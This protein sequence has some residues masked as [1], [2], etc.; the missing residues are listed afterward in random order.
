MWQVRRK[1]LLADRLTAETCCWLPAE[2]CPD[3]QQLVDA[4]RAG[5]ALQNGLTP[6]VGHLLG[7]VWVM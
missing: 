5:M 4:V 1:E 7:H 2:V 6:M 3:T